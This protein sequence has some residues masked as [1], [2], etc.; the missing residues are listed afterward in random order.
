MKDFDYRESTISYCYETRSV[1]FYFTRRSNYETCLRR[2][3][4]YIVAENLN[5]G[6]R[7]VYPFNQVR[8][9]EYLLRVPKVQNTA[10]NGSIST[11]EAA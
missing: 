8:T 11:L 2:N 6:F 1:E 9:P 3:P 4:H 5:P 7:V 10:E